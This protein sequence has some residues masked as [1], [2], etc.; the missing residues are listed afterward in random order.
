MPGLDRAAR[1]KLDRLEASTMIKDLAALA[2]N[3]FEALAGDRKASGSTT[4]GGYVLN[5]PKERSVHPR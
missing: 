2:G 1:L 4:S 3:R 5:G